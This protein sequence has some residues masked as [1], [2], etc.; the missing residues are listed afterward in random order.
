MLDRK[1][2]TSLEQCIRTSSYSLQ[3]DRFIPHVPRENILLLDFELLRMNPAAVVAQVSDFLDIEYIPGTG[4]IHNR[5]TS[6][7][8]LTNEQRAELANTVRPDVERLTSIYGFAPAER[9]LRRSL[10]SRLRFSGLRR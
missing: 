5:G 7:F 9:W 4:T 3:L 8:R 1:G 6:R 10:L 2:R